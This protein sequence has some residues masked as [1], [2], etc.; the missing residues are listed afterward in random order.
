MPKAE[1][2]DRFCQ[3]VKPAVGKQVD[4]FDTL[5]AGLCLRISP[6]GTKTFFQ[7]YTKPGDGKR[8]WLKLGRYPEMTLAAARKRAREARGEIG[9]GADPI[10]EKKALAASQTVA[11][12]VENY[13]ARHAA[14]KRS[15][16][17]IARRLRKNVVALIGTV[18]LADFHRRD[19][20]RCVDDVKDRGAGIEAN[21]VLKDVKAMVRW[22]R[23]RGDLDANIAEGMRMPTEAVERER[24][25]T[26][27]EIR[28]MWKALPDA[29]MRE[30]TRRVV[31]LC[32][33]TAQRVGEVAGMTVEEI[34]FDRALWA[35]PAP[36]RRT[37]ATIR[38][39][40][41]RWPSR[42]S[43]RSSPT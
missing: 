40:C 39:P 43:R 16:D 9:E 22:A 4:H 11:D 29:N 6:G 10:A 27:D 21:H 15:S 37:G 38:C 24:V 5:V 14:T 32:L 2:T 34:D 35:L 28:T 18:K 13:L 30:S 20:T 23:G 25:L 17:E 1:L 31:R 12:L 7:V 41:P 19:I 36:G 33:I 42:S 26:A 8:A 3:T